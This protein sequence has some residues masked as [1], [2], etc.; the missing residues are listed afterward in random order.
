MRTDPLHHTAL[1]DAQG[2]ALGIFMCSVG[3]HVLTYLGL[4]TGQTAGLAVILAYLT[5]LPFGVVFFVVNLPFYWIAWRRLGAEFTVKSLISVTLLS[6]LTELLPLGL[7]IERLH[8]GLGA[9]LFGSLVGIGLMA[10]FRHNGSL[11]G[12]GVV[13]LLLQDRGVAR[14]GHVQLAFDAALFAVAALL[15]PL[16]VVA[17][18]LLGAV[19]LNLIIAFN[20]RR[21]RYIA[22]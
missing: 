4:I 2:L 9:I 16:S 14:A 22:T 20:H 5:G 10:M 8:P 7:A 1:E 21:D 18:S 19:V 3:L 6:L 12:M 11:G 15:F 13:A 17:W